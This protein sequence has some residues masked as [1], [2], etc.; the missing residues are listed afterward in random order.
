MKKGVILSIA[1]ASI[2]V[3]TGCKKKTED[4]NKGNVVNDLLLKANTKEEKKY[5]Y[6]GYN[7]RQ[8]DIPLENINNIEYSNG[9]LVITTLD[10]RVSFYSVTINRLLEINLLVDDYVT[11]SSNVTGGFLKVI[12]EGVT[13]VYDALGNVLVE[14]DDETSS[15][16][17]VISGVDEKDREYCDVVLSVGEVEKHQYFIYDND[18]ATLLKVSEEDEFGSGSSMQGIEFVPLDDYG[19]KG[20]TRYKNSGRYV[21][22][23]DNNIEIASFT[24]PVA[25][26]EFFVGDYLIYQNSVR[27]DENNNDYDYIDTNGVRYSLETYRINYLTAKKDEL[28][29]NY[30]FQGNDSVFSLRNENS[31][32]QYSYA[33]VKIISSKR[34][35]SNTIEKYVIDGDAV[36]HDNVTGIF[37]S[38]FERFG[39]NY[40]DPIS[41]TIYDGNLN[42]ISILMNMSP[43]RITNADIIVCMRNGKYGAIN[44]EGKVV[45]EFKYDK[46]Y[47]TYI[48]NNRLLAV[49]KG[50]LCIYSFDANKCQVEAIKTYEGYDSATYLRP[51]VASGID[52]GVFYVTDKDNPNKNYYFSFYNTILQDFLMANGENLIVRID[53]ART[54]NQSTLVVL[55][56]IEGIYKLQTAYITITH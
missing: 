33:D 48:S 20:Y 17:R 35:L 37:I 31:I 2:L 30:V 53:T 10:T 25:D 28:D 56:Q 50:N 39:N 29:I 43:T 38:S 7:L 6:G 16:V 23:D 26:T 15:V 14:T 47:T 41:K 36:L 22:F 27:L 13:K 40:Y 42:E 51:F 32:Y 49:Y 24:D 46:I 5:I 19:H 34:I 4:N 9:F 45:F 8:N 55:Q 3:L 52:G 1:L 44:T 11:Y 18:V 12:S 54:I 21:V